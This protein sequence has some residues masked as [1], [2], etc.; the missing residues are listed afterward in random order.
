MPEYKQ[1]WERWIKCTWR[2]YKEFEK[3]MR[4]GYKAHSEEYWE[5]D[6]FIDR[7]NVDWDYCKENCRRVTWH[8]NQTQNKRC[9]WEYRYGISKKEIASKTWIKE[10]YLPSLLR[11]FNWDFEFF[12][13]EIEKKYNITL[14]YKIK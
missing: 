10:S 1:Y 6:T 5:K 3:D 8:E 4:E 14:N 2:D 7:I 11:K 12:I 9:M 13:K